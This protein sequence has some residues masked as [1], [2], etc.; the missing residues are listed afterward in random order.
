[1]FDI[2]H[3]F[4]YIEGKHTGIRNLHSNVSREYDYIPGSCVIAFSSLC[5]TCSTKTTQTIIPPLKPIIST[6][7]WSRLQIDLIDLRKLPD[8]EYQYA[9]HCVD[10]FTK[11]HFLIA[12][13]SKQAA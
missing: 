4:H 10:H 9:G 12:M 6:G 11:Y 13:K 1:M 2:L 5:P 8:G 7:F 3:R